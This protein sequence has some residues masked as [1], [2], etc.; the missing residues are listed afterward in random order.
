MGRRLGPARRRSIALLGFAAAVS[1]PVYGWAMQVPFVLAA[2]AMA[3]VQWRVDRL[4]RPEYAIAAVWLFTELA[5]V[6]A[7]GLAHGPRIYALPV[8]M[9]PTLAAAAVFPRRVV[10]IGTAISAALMLVAGLTLMPAAVAATPPVLILPMALLVVISLLA[11]RTAGVEA[12]SRQSVVADQL[13]GLLNRTALQARAAE[14]THHLSGPGAPEIAVILCDVDRFKTVNDEHGHAVGDAVL[15]EVAQ[16]LRRAVG[17]DGSLYRFGGEEFVVLLEAAGSSAAPELAERMRAA[18]RAEAVA[19]LAVTLSLGVASSTLGARDC[20]ALVAIADRALYRAKAGGRDRVCLAGDSDSR[21]ALRAVSPN[22]GAPLERRLRTTDPPMSD[23]AAPTAGTAEERH[24]P[25]RWL[26]LNYTAAEREHLL[27]HTKRAAPVSRIAQPLLLIALIASGP[28]F[29]WTLLIPVVVSLTVMMVMFVVIMPRARHPEYPAL[30]G[31]LVILV[32]T[33]LG[34]LL[35]RHHALFALPF[36]TTLI[37]SAAAG[38]PRPSAVARSVVSAGVVMIAVALLVGAHTVFENPAILVFPLALL[39]SVALFGYAIG[40]STLDH[41]AVAAVDPLTGALSRAALHSRLCELSLGDAAIDRPVS[42][43]IAD[44]D[45]FKAIN[46]EH[47]H[48]TGDQVLAEIA[49]RLRAGVRAFDSVYRIGGEEFL[50]APD[51]RRRACRD[52]RGR[53]DPGRDPR[54]AGRRAPA[55]RLARRG[56][57]RRRSPAGLR[58]AVRRRR[59]RAAR[60]QGTRSRPRSDGAATATARHCRLSG[61]PRVRFA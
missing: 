12:H 9:F 33:G 61:R 29:G 52:C 36:L 25:L 30:A 50:D 19:G 8:L 49:A 11:S 17:S 21:A 24:G 37:F 10:T 1:I 51:G 40:Q 22:A 26:S 7:I 47:G 4:R 58:R 15:R 46:D 54:P 6:V 56:H 60:R 14:L 39:G 57:P 59:R 32:G 34:I 18:V 5:M 16:R 44:L 45:H 31:S 38:A 28:W 55:D 53:A 42:I 27:D 41:R 3:A 20:D 35:A 43:V 23:A 13:T 48:M 2:A